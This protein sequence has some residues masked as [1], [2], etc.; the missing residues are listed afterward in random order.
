[1]LFF[2]LDHQD[3]S[4]KLHRYLLDRLTKKLKELEQKEIDQWD[5]QYDPDP[6][7][8]LPQHVFQKLNEKVLKE[9]EEVNKALSKAK[10]SAPKHIDYKDELI[11]ITDALRMLEDDDIDAK[12]KN[13]YLK[14]IIEKIEYERGQIVRISKANAKKYDVDTSKGLQY[15]THPYKIRIKLK[16]D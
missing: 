5:A 2:L 14:D 1:M 15:H 6:N 16:C 3:D 10:K 12:T 11:K 13:Q 4:V 9:K 7:K 8:R